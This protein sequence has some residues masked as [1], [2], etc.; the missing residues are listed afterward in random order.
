MNINNIISEEINKFLISEVHLKEVDNIKEITDF[1]L[2]TWSSPTDMW[3]IKLDSRKKDW[4][5]RNK[6]NPNGKPKMWS[7][8]GGEDGTGRENHVGYAIVRGRTK[9]DA[10]RSLKYAVVHLN[11]WAA[12][13]LGGTEKL[14]SNGGC[15]AIKTACNV[16][17]ARAYITINQRDIGATIERSRA[18]KKKGMFKNREFHHRAGQARTGVDRSGKDWSVERKF[19]LVDCDVDNTQAQSW[20]ENYFA[21]KGVT[22][23]F[24]KP[25]FDGMHYF[26]T[27]DDGNKCDWNYINKYMEKNYNT[28]NRPGDPPVLFKPDANAM[29]YS[30]VG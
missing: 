30:N 3:W 10:I 9:E 5:S 4:I 6:R 17:F 28:R 29:L 11:P 25:S 16:F 15:E 14:Y 8:V 24:K 1:I 20:L 21:Q 2:S 18:D 27:I 22:V 13:I 7:S 26:I 19:G 23:H 12:K